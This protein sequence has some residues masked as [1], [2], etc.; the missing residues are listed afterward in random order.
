MKILQNYL[1]AL[2][3]ASVV[4]APDEEIPT[5]VITYEAD[6]V[7][8]LGFV[9]SLCNRLATADDTPL[10]S[11]REE[12]RGVMRRKLL[13][14]SSLGSLL[15]LVLRVDFSRFALYYPRHTQHPFVSI[16]ESAIADR[17]LAG[18]DLRQYPQFGGDL[19][20]L[21][22]R[23]NGCV[24]DLRRQ[25]RAAGMRRK[26]DDFT[27]SARKNCAS[28]K[29]YFS[30]VLQAHGAA[31]VHRAEL[32]FRK[33]LLWPN[34][35]DQVGV[36]YKTVRG[37]V[38][39]LRDILSEL[40]E[41]YLLGHVLRLDNSTERGYVLHVVFFVNPDMSC[42]QTDVVI[43]F[44]NRKWSEITTGTGACYEYGNDIAF[45]QTSLKR[46]GT[47]L[48]YA[49]N[50]ESQRHLNDAAMY[51][52][53]LDSFVRLKVPGRDRALWRGVTP[54]IEKTVYQA[55]NWVGAFPASQRFLSGNWP[56]ATCS[57]I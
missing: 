4:Y 34:G 33:G 57:G 12:G 49:N 48:C 13:H 47:G 38:A 2:R 3:E 1:S 11:I 39:R 50:P 8:D 35:T 36:D 42:E 53:M 43:D 41:G 52:S 55:T 56:T 14:Q 21:V 51:L 5:W 29:K 32:F 46:C 6:V 16:V 40:P 15:A 44:V 25:L 18:F 54:K 23:L 28:L 7:A 9:I 31:I 30:A 10:F 17:A 45:P 19:V 37:Y 24:T 27:R 20:A 26:A 22:D